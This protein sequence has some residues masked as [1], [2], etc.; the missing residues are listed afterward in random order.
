MIRIGT[1][2]WHYDHWRGPFYPPRMAASRML[3][4]YIGCFDTVELNNSFYRL[5][6]KKALQDW[7]DE[8]PRAFCFA[9]KGSR[10]LTHAKKLKD[11]EEGIAR[12][13]DRAEILGP[14]LGPVLFQLPPQWTVNAERLDQFLEALPEGHRYAFEFRNETWNC[15]DV[16]KV[17]RAHR[18]AY[19]VFDLAGYQSPLTVTTDFVYVRLHG[20]G[21]KYQ[22]SYSDAALRQWAEQ[23][24]EWKAK[25]KHVYVYFDNDDSGYAPKNALKLKTMLA[26]S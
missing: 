16:A 19:C 13:F 18:A 6:S 21:A 8:T 10:Y 14:K 1:S 5:P 3:G 7:R 12:F 17:L 25:R 9:V 20:P 22:G 24:R 26:D 4:Y 2:G 15:D 11:P 23:I